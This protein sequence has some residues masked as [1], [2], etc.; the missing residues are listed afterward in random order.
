MLSGSSSDCLCFFYRTEDKACH[1]NISRSS[2]RRAAMHARAQTHKHTTYLH[3]WVHK[4]LSLPRFHVQIWMFCSIREKTG[5]FFF[6]TRGGLK[7]TRERETITHISWQ[8]T[9]SLPQSEIGGSAKRTIRNHYFAPNCRWQAWARQTRK[10]IDCNTFSLCCTHLL[11][12]SPLL[13]KCIHLEMIW[14]T[15]PTSGLE[16]VRL[17][18]KLLYIYRRLCTV[19]L[20]PS[21]SWKVVF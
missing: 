7:V 18:R 5:L 2:S 17:L 16:T 19:Q 12:C 8:I 1:N 9:I 6:S 20:N 3:I 13:N 4:R 14:Q 15:V 11:I 10:W 21:P